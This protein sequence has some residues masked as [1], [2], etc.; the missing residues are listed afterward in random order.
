VSARPAGGGRS[1][2]KRPP[3]QKSAR[4]IA[5]I[6]LYHVDTRKAF[7]DLLLSRELK[8]QPLA[9][10]DA[11]FAT[12]LVNGTLRWRARL[13]WVLERY[14]R[15]GLDTLSPWVH[16]IL[17]MGVYQ[18]LFLDRVPAH[19]AVDEAVTL[20]KRY[21][22]PGAAGLVNGVLRK[23][24]REGGEVPDP[25]R[26]IEDSAGALAV[27]GSH[28]RWL[29]E[30]W[31]RRLGEEETRALMLANNQPRPLGL[32]V[33]PLRTDR[34]TLHRSLA[35]RGVATEASPLSRLS[36]RV[37]GNLVLAGLP[38][39]EQGTFFVQDESETVVGELVGAEPGETVLDL[40]AAP[41]GKATQIQEG[42]GSK[43]LLIAVDT[44]MNR[45][46]RVKENVARMGVDNVG[47]VCA[48][49]RVLALAR[50][51]DRVLVDAPCSGLGV[52]G[53]RADAR[54]RK[55]EASLRSLVAL[56]R[57][58]LQAGAT[59]VRPG[60]ILVYSVCSTEPEE[61]MEQVRRFLRERPEFELQDASE[62]VASEAV[63][64]RCVLLYPHRHG[65]DGA[66]AARM[67][68]KG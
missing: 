6:V 43:G 42:R 62:F 66:F 49:G 2:E 47:I 46:S 12:E 17:R 59:H 54:W 37:T 52:L 39:F 61:G 34:E 4:E 10:R 45:L 38:E 65:T 28:P 30:R 1:R 57:E 50:P 18:L 32:R 24:L 23:I 21:A 3:R 41:G 16:N 8:R 25:E 44:V 22:N 7:A 48:D 11:A 40:A 60:G 35:A 64:E 53:R 51:V 33:N 20:T 5:L 9:P 31:L 56:E 15:A 27:V 26:V 29:V 63:T 68:R 14:V 58:L 36:L 55:T 67:R 19:A 13:D